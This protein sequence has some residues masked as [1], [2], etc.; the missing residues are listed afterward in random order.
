MKLSRYGFEDMFSRNISFLT[1]IQTTITVLCGGLNLCGIM[2][3]IMKNLRK[4]IYRFFQLRIILNKEQV[5]IM[6]KSL[7]TSITNYKILIWGG[8][9][10]SS[11]SLL[12][13]QCFLRTLAFITV[14]CV[15]STAFLKIP[16][17]P[18]PLL[19]S[20]FFPYRHVRLVG[21]LLPTLT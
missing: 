15:L 6:C 13:V 21:R 12:Q 4:L 3:W 8:T 18:V 20:I 16:L 1:V 11:F 17:R 2:N 7:V 10:W 5:C 19:P 14:F 9:W